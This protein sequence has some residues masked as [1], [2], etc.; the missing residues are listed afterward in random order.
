[1]ANFGVPEY[2]LCA[3]VGAATVIAILYTLAAQIRDYAAV[4]QLR[5]DTERVRREFAKRARGADDGDILVVDVVE[6]EP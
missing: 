6:D 1:M 4:T 2:V 3:A 5:V